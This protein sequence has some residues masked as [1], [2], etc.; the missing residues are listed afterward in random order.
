MALDAAYVESGD[1]SLVAAPFSLTSTLESLE[2]LLIDGQPRPVV[3]DLGLSS[4]QALLAKA[5]TRAF[6]AHSTHASHG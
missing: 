5:K 4:P 3:T 1:V 2:S 6:V